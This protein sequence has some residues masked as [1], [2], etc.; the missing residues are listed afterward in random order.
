MLTLVGLQDPADGHGRHVAA[1]Y[2]AVEAAF[3]NDLQWHGGL[4]TVD[5]SGLLGQSTARLREFWRVN[6][7]RL[8]S[9]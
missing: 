2:A 7:G 1:Q 9:Q 6:Y 5:V 8:H 4:C 3:K